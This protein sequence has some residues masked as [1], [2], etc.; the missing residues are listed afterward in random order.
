MLTILFRFFWVNQIE[1]EMPDTWKWFFQVDQKANI[2]RLVLH[3]NKFVTRV[4]KAL[5]RA[6]IL[7]EPSS[8]VPRGI[9]S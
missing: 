6:T 8:N 3:L 7:C 2:R 1:T 5:I 9:D 4:A